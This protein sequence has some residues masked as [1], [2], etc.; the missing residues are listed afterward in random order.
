MRPEFERLIKV[1][2]RWL[3]DVTGI[4]PVTSCLQR[5]QGQKLNA[6]IGVAYTLNPQ[7]FRSSNIPNLYR[8]HF[9]QFFR[10][11]ARLAVARSRR[12]MMRGLTPSHIVK[13]G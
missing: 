12:N 11:P 4:E 1:L 6:L 7:D 13:Y 5:E 10:H 2:E 9:F 8:V 3:V